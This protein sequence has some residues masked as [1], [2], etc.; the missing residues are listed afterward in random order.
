MNYEEAK[1]HK[2]K[3]DESNNVDVNKLKAFDKYKNAMGITPDHIRVLPEWKIAIESFARSFDELRKFNGWFVKT[4]KKEYE[5]D[6]KLSR[7]IK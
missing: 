4:F 5:A 7:K 1:I 6:R 3:L 2:Q